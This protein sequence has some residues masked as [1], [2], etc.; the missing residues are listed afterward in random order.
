MC[1]YTNML[2]AHNVSDSPNPTTTDSFN[3]QTFH[4]HVTPRSNFAGSVRP[5]RFRQPH[6]MHVH[7]A[8]EHNMAERRDLHSTCSPRTLLTTAF[9]PITSRPRGPPY[10]NCF[11]QK[12]SGHDQPEKDNSLTCLARWTT[13]WCSKPVTNVFVAPLISN[14]PRRDNSRCSVNKIWGGPL[15]VW[16]QV[17]Y[18]GLMIC[19]RAVIA[20]VTV[21]LD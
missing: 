21:M 8:S 4:W 3:N 14:Y 2:S 1:L 5:S 15:C 17:L 7:C 16:N 20:C 6:A 13:P 11:Q 12:E 19:H 9:T 18:H 10:I